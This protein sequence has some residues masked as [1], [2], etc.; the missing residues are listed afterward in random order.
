MVLN[1]PG[2]VVLFDF[3]EVIS[4]SV[5]VGQTVAASL[6]A[7]VIFTVTSAHPLEDAAVSVGVLVR[8]V[9]GVARRLP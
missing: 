1:I 2:R 3:G 6:Q 4:R 9:E 7:P 5:D 8:V